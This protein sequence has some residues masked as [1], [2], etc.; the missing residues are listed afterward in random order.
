MKN[1]VTFSRF[2]AI[3]LKI[4]DMFQSQS[5]DKLI[6][7]GLEFKMSPQNVNEKREQALLGNNTCIVILPLCYQRNFSIRGNH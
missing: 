6:H 5:V 4:Q 7:L 2:A 1:P 3:L